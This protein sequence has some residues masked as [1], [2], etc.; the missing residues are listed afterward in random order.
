M[1]P[2]AVL[3]CPPQAE[4]DLGTEIASAAPRP[5]LIVHLPRLWTTAFSLRLNWQ[6]KN[7]DREGRELPVPTPPPFL[8]TDSADPTR[9]YTVALGGMEQSRTFAPDRHLTLREARL[10]AALMATHPVFFDTLEVGRLEMG[11]LYRNFK[12]GPDGRDVAGG[13]RLAELRADL[14]KLETYWLRVDR[15][16]VKDSAQ[17]VADKLIR[18]RKHTQ[19]AAG[20]PHTESNVTA[21]WIEAFSINGEFLRVVLD[22]GRAVRLDVLNRFYSEM[23][24]AW[25]L[26]IPALASHPRIN[27]GN[28]WSRNLR[29]LFHLAGVSYNTWSAKEWRKKRCAKLIE[30]QFD[31]AETMNGRIRARLQL[32]ADKTDYLLLCWIEHAERRSISYN[33]EGFLYTYWLAAGK[34][35]AEFEERLRRGLSALSEHEIELLEHAR[36]RHRIPGNHAFLRQIKAFLGESRFAFALHQAKV[37]V[38]QYLMSGGC[39]S[40]RIVGTVLKDAYKDLLRP[41]DRS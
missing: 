12:T 29:D 22:T 7:L 11:P 35:Q 8:L 28:P 31:G 30:E 10:L 3:P 15:P 24:Q 36:Y 4:I 27:A 20:R 38:A 9:T 34:T 25:Y 19:Y 37:S 41:K 33:P 6:T 32:N 13:Q 26:V 40:G 23:L 16:W 17:V 1:P 18:F 5:P 21:E 39:D 2:P 14:E